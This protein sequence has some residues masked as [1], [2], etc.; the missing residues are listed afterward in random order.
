MTTVQLKSVPPELQTL[1]SQAQTD[2]LVVR[3]PDGAEFLLTTVDEFDL[4]VVRTRANEEL[5]TFL[6]Q[7]AREPATVTLED[8][9]QRLGT[10]DE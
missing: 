10:R 7:R 1:L 8:I 5:M 6:E 4:E 2:A 3:T 9:R